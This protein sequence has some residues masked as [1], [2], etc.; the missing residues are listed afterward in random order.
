MEVGGFCFVDDFVEVEIV[1]VNICGFI[2]QVKKDFVDILLVVVDFKGNGIMILVVVV[3]CM[4]ECYGCE[5]VEFLFEV[6]V[7]LG[8]DDYGDIV[9]WL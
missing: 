1:V 6:D 4:V 2:E 9:G 5:F 8:F 3:G 7:V